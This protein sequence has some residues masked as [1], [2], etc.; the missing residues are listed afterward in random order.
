MPKG[1]WI[2]LTLILPCDYF[3]AAIEAR[4][5]SFLPSFLSLSF[6][7]LIYQPLHQLF[8]SR[9]LFFTRIQRK[10]PP[11]H[12]NSSS[13]R[14]ICI[15]CLVA[16]FSALFAEFRWIFYYSVNEAVQNIFS[17]YCSPFWFR[18]ALIF[19]LVC[20]CLTF[21]SFLELPSVLQNTHKSLT[22][23]RAS[24]N[25]IAQFFC[26]VSQLADWFSLT[27]CICCCSRI[28]HI[29]AS[30]LHWAHVLLSCTLFFSYY[31]HS[32]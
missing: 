27:Y 31:V 13:S 15:C 19:L 14:S 12:C 25:L 8:N 28:F 16:R 11:A 21:C 3:C 10:W 22:S 17:L 9:L 7:G 5:A 1:C 24:A 18:P 30:A 26:P 29:Q 2:S 20:V 23:P 6:T 32:I 4:S